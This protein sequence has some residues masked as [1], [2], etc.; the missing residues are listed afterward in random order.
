MGAGTPSVAIVLLPDMER[1]EN[2]TTPLAHDRSVFAT[3]P[4]TALEHSKCCDS[5]PNRQLGSCHSEVG[6]GA[7]AVTGKPATLTYPAHEGCPG[8]IFSS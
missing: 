1:A 7:G 2:R 3:N 6:V 8:T 5:I 4:T